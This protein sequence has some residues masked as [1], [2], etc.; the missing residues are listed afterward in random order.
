MIAFI[1]RNDITTFSTSDIKG[2]G[3]IQGHNVQI[4]FILSVVYE[5]EI[6]F[7]RHYSMSLKCGT[8]VCAETGY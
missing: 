2:D 4:I 6:L 5:R 3:E 1:G 7:E 8:E